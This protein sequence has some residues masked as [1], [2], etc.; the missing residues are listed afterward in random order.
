ME[1]LKNA[2]SAKIINRIKFQPDQ[3]CS[4]TVIF[5]II[6][7]IENI[8]LT[9]EKLVMNTLKNFVLCNLTIN[10]NF[11]FVLISM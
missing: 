10:E 1:S 4:S 7:K 5:R 6:N 2:V 8:N 11:N 3:Y 9:L